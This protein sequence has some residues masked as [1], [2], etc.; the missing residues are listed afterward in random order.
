MAWP[1]VLVLDLDT[2]T[3]RCRA[4]RWTSPKTATVDEAR[5][6]YARHGCTGRPVRSPLLGW[7]AVCGRVRL[8]GLRPAGP[9]S[10]APGS[11]PGSAR[12][13]LAASGGPHV[14]SALAP[15]W[16]LLLVVL[17]VGFALAAS[18]ASGPPRR[19]EPYDPPPCRLVPG[20][21]GAWSDAQCLRARPATIRQE[22]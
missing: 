19:P 4:C 8:G 10:R 12:T 18:I 11:V 1:F 17:L 3:V 7:C 16:W 13:G 20:P 15:P 5:Q 6:A 22:R 9:V 2:I 14:D 21:A